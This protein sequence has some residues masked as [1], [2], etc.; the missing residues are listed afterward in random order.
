MKTLL[1]LASLLVFIAA[2]AVA[3]Q[4]TSSIRNFLRVNEQ[5]CT[6]GQ[7]RLEHLEQLKAEGVKAIINLRQPTEHRAAEEEA[8]AKELGLRYFNIPVKFGDPKDEQADEFLKITDDPQNRPAFIHCTAAIR[9]GA[10]WLI[11][12]VLRDGWKFEDAEKE[13]E[14]VGLRESPHLNEFARKYIEKHRQQGVAPSRPNGAATPN[15]APPS[16]SAN[17]V[18]PSH[19]IAFGVFVARFDP[20]GTFTLEGDRRPKLNGNWKAHGNEIELSMTGGPGGCDNPGKYRTTVDGKRIT[21]DLVSDDCRPRQMILDRSTW[22]PAGESAGKPV[23]KI[24]HTS[25]ARPPSRAKPANAAGSWPSFRGPNASGVAEA[26]NLPDKWDAK[27][28]E[29]ILWRTPIPGLSHSSPIVWGN[30]VYVTSAVSSDPKATFRPGLY[31]DGDAA[32]DRSTHKWIIYAIDKQTGKFAWERVAFEGEPR[33]KRHI[34]ATYANSTPATDGRIVVAWFGSQG[35]YAYDV[36][37]RFLWKVDLGRIDLGAYDIPTFEWGSASSPII[38]KDLVILQ[39]DTQ[40]DSFIVA[41]NANTGE[42]VWKTDRDEIP[43]WGTPT[44]ATTSKGDELIANASNFIRG[45]DPRTGKEL[46]RLGKSS[47]I[48]APTPIF[49]DDILVFASGRGPERPIFVVKAGARGDLTLPDGKTSSEAIIWSRTGRGSYMPTPLIYKGVLY[50]LAN[51][52]TFD[53]YN[54]KTGDEL[55]RQRLPLVGNGFSASPIAADGKIYLPNEDGEILV[56]SAG[57]KFAHVATNS[58]GELLMATPALSE[59]VMYVRTAQ[60]LFAVGR[61]K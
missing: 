50:V 52:G 14:K 36:N 8:K 27:T 25:H 11:R 4:E 49:A 21:F 33:E 7:P 30:R 31:G 15:G 44:V 5:F 32:K 35:V 59:G 24:V 56:V 19:P 57:E 37:G 38:W 43:S 22:L 26:Q 12:R 1:C 3:Q 9:V 20:A 40:T 45:Y 28:G 46:W 42:T 39:C 6:G 58:M 53:A 54:L 48:T 61:K 13:A 18:L 41:L 16:Q 2:L 51:N 23:R 10:F 34:K 55:Y 60:S 17:S 29:N 47:K